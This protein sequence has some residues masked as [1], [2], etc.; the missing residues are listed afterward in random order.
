MPVHNSDV[1]DIF[2]RIADLLEIKGENLFRIRAYR[3]AARTVGGLSK[4]V[5]DLVENGKDLSVLPGIGKDLA[6]KIKK[7][8]KTG[9]HPLLQELEKELPPELPDLMKIQGM[10]PRKVKVL[11]E[12]LGIKSADDLKKAAE[13]GKIQKLEGFGRQ[14]EKN[15]LE[16]LIWIKKKKGEKERIKLSVAEQIAE[17]LIEYL[18]KEKGVRE[19]EVAGS[20]RRRKETVGD[21]DILA[22]CRKGSDVMDRFAGYDEVK[23]I[24]S[25]GK[26]KSSVVL[27]SGLQVDLRVVA[28][29]SF[30]SALHYF[31]GSKEHNI[32][33][34][35]MGLKKGLKINEYG[36]FRGKRRIAG[37]TEGEVYKQV[38]LPYIEPELRENRGEIE[39]AKNKSLPKLIVLEDIK[40]DLHVHTKSTD[41]H[42][43]AEE[44]A[45][46]AKKK[47]YEYVA[48]TDHSK[49]VTI[50]RGMDVKRLLKQ[51]GEIDRL[52][53]KT[54]GI[55]I[56][57]SIELDILEDGSLDLPDEVLED[58]DLVICSIHYKFNLSREKQT[59]RII[60]AMEN[61][62]FNIFSHPTGRLLNE[63]RPYEINME[64]VMKAARENG[65]YLELN[66]HPDRL[67]LNDTDCKMAKD[68]GVMVAISTDA[69]RTDDLDL[70]R[71]GIGQARRGW[72]ESGDVLNTRSW[73]E[74]EKLLKRK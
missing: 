14:T 3:N 1:S 49:H 72:L 53:R 15:L 67:D 13:E 2:N 33:V 16:E 8:V 70:M 54:R 35:K 17:P 52:N 46:A 31:T 69:H 50:A 39:A 18:K 38:G 21:L 28:Q 20:Y 34:R 12:K 37:K 24:L 44:M 25:K 48:I 56:L 40:G 61:P 23:K 73:E 7:I 5:S 22:T 71:F 64:Q 43:S 51:I 10:G 36:V 11:F 58:L 27:R 41:G 26:T 9:S 57:K 45:E 66:A 47:G 19:M 30:G 60:R 6:E 62:H 4:S 68:L 32:A 55:L 65:C 74:L 42:Y 63:R 29:T 59:E